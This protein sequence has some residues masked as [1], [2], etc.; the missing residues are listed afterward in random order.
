MRTGML[1]AR[2]RSLGVQQRVKPHAWQH[3]QTSPGGIEGRKPP[4][5]RAFGLGPAWGQCR[6]ADSPEMPEGD[7]G[8][9]SGRGQRGSQTTPG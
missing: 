4:A 2:L 3:S 6:P 7:P 1:V 8:A 5:L 9:E